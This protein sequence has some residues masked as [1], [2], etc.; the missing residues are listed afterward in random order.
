MST[1]TSTKIISTSL[2]GYV[3]FNTASTT[4]S[5]LRSSTGNIGDNT[6]VAVVLLSSA[7]TNQYEN[8]NRAIILFD[9]SVI[10]A[11]AT[12]T[13]ASLILPPV[14]IQ[15]NLGST[16]IEIVSSNPA[17]NSSI[18]VT[19]YNTLGSTSFAS[20]AFASLSGSSTN[21]IPFNSS[22][23]ANI[24]IGSV[25]KF[26]FVLGWDLTNTPPTWSNN[27]FSQVY[28]EAPGFGVP[29]GI[30][31]LSLTYTQPTLAITGIGSTISNINSITTS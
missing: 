16:T 7:T 24:S 1:V 12:I 10:P 21:T 5:T 3:G 11:N 25:S 26:G 30:A 27:T 29:T 15:T 14:S 17:S 4:F 2:Q 22:G 18:T 20:V 23:I 31:Q 6:I 13:S 9:T 8:L 19:D 28:Y